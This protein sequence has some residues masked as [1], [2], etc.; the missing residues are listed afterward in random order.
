MNAPERAT[1]IKAAIAATIAFMTAL[2]GWVGWAII[3]W[4]GCVVL[5]YL[6]GTAAAQKAGEW[7]SSIARAGLW[8]KLGEIFAAL[9]AALCDVALTVI[10]K[11]TGIEIG[12]DVGPLITPVV[13]MWY[14]ITELG[15]IVEN[16]GKLGAPVPAWLKRLL[17]QYKNSIDQ[18][19]G[20]GDEPETVTGEPVEQEVGKH[21]KVSVKE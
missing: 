20:G 17:K 21:E 3:I 19:H 12:L 5:D 15:S 9:V 16:A 14:I 18:Q 10:L 8:H 6:A 11:G 2:W 4:L 13:L 7:S 1:E